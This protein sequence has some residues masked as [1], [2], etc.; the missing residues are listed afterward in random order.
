M[1]YVVFIFLFVFNGLS[2]L[3]IAQK[4]KQL[5]GRYVF[6]K[7]L[8]VSDVGEVLVLQKSADS[9]L[10][11]VSVSKAAPSYSTT[12]LF[13]DLYIVNSVSYYL[14]N[15][16][17]ECSLTFEFEENTLTI[18]QNSSSFSCGA[19]HLNRTFIKVESNEPQ[20]FYLGNGEKVAFSDKSPY[21]VKNSS[22]SKKNFEWN[23][24]LCDYTGTLKELEFSEVFL[25]KADLMS[26]KY[27]SE[28]QNLY[29]YLKNGISIDSLIN[30]LEERYTKTK[31]DYLSLKS[32][33]AGGAN[34]I[35]LDS[36]I[37]ENIESI[38]TQF[39]IQK[40]LLKSFNNPKYL[41]E[42][43]YY[44]SIKKAAQVLNES[45]EE[46]E[47]YFLR[48]FQNENGISIENMKDRIFYTQVEH[49][50]YSSFRSRYQI[51]IDLFYDVTETCMDGPY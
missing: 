44:G 41:I 18:I 47:N 6:G 5:T 39:E 23:V 1:R 20:F 8:N 4:P 26:D 50:L 48:E 46:I 19:A 13:T 37:A 25:E 43:E 21:F 29:S 2:T 31:E 30:Q 22:R 36:F 49:V 12:M 11:Y 10:V 34:S 3:A 51:F 7:D 28:R 42:S 45:D 40:T 17:G 38:E 15:E 16:L 35:Q 14:S 27:D 24:G 32:F 33:Q 9:L